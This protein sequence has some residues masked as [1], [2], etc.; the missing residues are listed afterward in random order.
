MGDLDLN[1]DIKWNKISFIDVSN[2][3]KS[4]NITMIRNSTKKFKEKYAYSSAK[5]L[6]VMNNDREES[7]ASSQSIR[8]DTT[9][10]LNHTRSTPKI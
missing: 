6:Q 5:K 3:I 7:E 4:R 1:S 2:K 10:S 9:L 8:F